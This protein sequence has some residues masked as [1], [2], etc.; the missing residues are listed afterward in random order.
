MAYNNGN[1]RGPR[2]SSDRFGNP[3]QLKFAKEVVNKK[4]G[5]VVANCFSAYFELGGKLYKIEASPANK[6]GKNGEH[7]IWLKVTRR[8]QQKRQTSM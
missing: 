6:E 8:D 2:I 7:G 4:T 5:D 1:N 3:M